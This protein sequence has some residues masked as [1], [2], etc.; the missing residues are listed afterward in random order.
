[1]LYFK[2]GGHMPNP[3]SLSWDA[4]KAKF[5][6]CEQ[7][8]FEWLCYLLF[9]REHNRPN[10]ILRYFN[11]AGIETEPIEHDGHSVGFQAK[12]LMDGI[13]GKKT[14]I[15][16][17]ISKA[18]KENPKLDRILYYLPCEFAKDPKNRKPPKYKTDIEQYARGIGIE[19]DWRVPSHFEAQLMQ[20][21]NR[22]LLEYFFSLD[23]GVI[24]AIKKLHDHS[25]Q[26][27]NPIKTSI[28]PSGKC[29]HFDRSSAIEQVMQALGQSV[30]II[31]HGVGGV[32]KTAIIKEMLGQ[33]HGFDAC[34]VV[35]TSELNTDH[36][37][38]LFRHYG[39]LT[40]TGFIDE[41]K[42]A[43]RKLFV[44]DSVESLSDFD[45]RGPFNTLVEELRKAGWDIVFTVR[46]LYFDEIK[47]M[48]DCPTVDV[49]IPKLTLD[50][51][52]QISRQHSIVLPTNERVQE[53]MCTP[54]YL[55]EYLSLQG[56]DLT[57]SLNEF[58]KAVWKQRIEDSAHQKGGIDQRRAK[59][60]I[61]L[62]QERC[63]EGTY[64]LDIP[65]DHDAYSALVHDE[66]LE[67]HSSTLCFITHDVYEEWALE[68]ILETAFVQQGSLR[69]MLGQIDSSLPMRRAFRDWLYE[70]IE[71]DGDN[72]QSNIQT[73]VRGKEIEPF[74][75]DEVLVALMKSSRIGYLEI[76]HDD[77]PT[78]NYS[79][80]DRM[81][82]LLLVGCSAPYFDTMSSASTD[83]DFVRHARYKLR[84]PYGKGWE[85]LITFATSLPRPDLL[86]K[87]AIP[88]FLAWTANNHAGAATRSAGLWALNLYRE[89]FRDNDY[90]TYIYKNKA[91]EIVP[92]ILNSAGEIKTELAEFLDT[93]LLKREIRF[94]DP[95]PKAILADLTASVEIL[96]ALPGFVIK[97]AWRFW[98]VQ[99]IE[100][101]EQ[102]E[103]RLLTAAFGISSDTQQYYHPSS[104][105]QTPILFLLRYHPR[106][107]L[108]FIIEFMN[109]AVANYA[110]SPRKDE[111]GE[112]YL[113]FNDGTTT[114]QFINA[115][116]WGIY[117]G[118]SS[119]SAILESIHMALERW[120]LLKDQGL[121]PE[122]QET[123]CMDLLKRSQSA[124]IT[125][126]VLSVVQAFPD[127]LFNV[128]AILL[129]V[130]RFYHLE[131]SRI[132]HELTANSLYSIGYGL[133][134]KKLYQDERIATCKDT[135][136]LR[137]LEDLILAYQWY[138]VDT[139]EEL[140]RRKQVAWG[141][142]DDLHRELPPENEQTNIDKAW[143][144]S[145]A[146]M[147]VRKMKLQYV[148]TEGDMNYFQP[149]PE[150]DGDL[151]QFQNRINPVSDE[152]LF[153]IPLQL[154]LRARFENN[155]IEYNKFPNY[156]VDP[157]SA[158]NEADE[159]TKEEE[160]GDD[161]RY[162]LLYR[163]API[164]VCTVLLRDFF[165]L[166]NAESMAFCADLILTSAIALNKEGYQ[167]SYRN[168]IAEITHGLAL[169]IRH[170]SANVV[171]AKKL[172]FTMVLGDNEVSD[173]ARQCV[174]ML[175]W[176]GNAADAQSLLAGYLRLVPGYRDYVQKSRSMEVHYKKGWIE[177]YLDSQ[178][179]VVNAVM[180]NTIAISDQEPSSLPG[181][182][183][184]TAVEMLPVS[185]LSHELKSVVRHAVQKV[186]SSLDDD[187]DSREFRMIESFWG[188]FSY[189]LFHLD[190]MEIKDLLDPF[191]RI[192]RASQEL[193]GLLSHI[194]LAEN[195]LNRP[196]TFWLI[197]NEFFELIT[198]VST[199]KDRVAGKMICKYLVF[200]VFDDKV[201]QWHSLRLQ[202][203]SF[204]D[205][206][207]HKMGANPATLDSIAKV[208]NS[209]ASPFWKQGIGWLAEL[210]SQ[211]IYQE[212]PV[213]T[214]YYIEEFMY[215]SI[216]RERRVIRQD[217]SLRECSILI[218]DFIINQ[219]SSQGYLLREEIL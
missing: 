165:P 25:Q 96:K 161:S 138:G 44:F 76:L 81:L 94:N 73:V 30:P 121:A 62:V 41:H 168:R 130:R 149:I 192:R 123:V 60:F 23:P 186:A 196:D 70:K 209:I 127:R 43:A 146:N 57:I 80:L 213:D 7:A 103:R 163:S 169:L 159:I 111:L 95:L 212:L 137:R 108:D 46:T 10:G 110:Q 66:I 187:R 92:I 190:E 90:V 100:E 79:L 105:F 205:K 136:R 82:L 3:I 49:E 61:E 125:A 87:W 199:L 39:S 85:E 6:G 106:Q 184:V 74:W 12:F 211:N 147:D 65:N 204:Y 170:S 155:P 180:D 141:I 101:D 27:L 51:L 50:E 175:L 24:E 174:C 164:A 104:A 142:L 67:K 84:I 35:K 152:I 8:N 102:F 14:E 200:D 15:T 124:S 4:F 218:L 171:Q 210:V 71:A 86:S 34:Y 178:S 118:L 214:I 26:V 32:G 33:E 219:G 189:I 91:R 68:H 89:F 166:L 148:K 119:A 56:T 126:V 151:R 172:L 18:K 5:N 28:D 131:K 122:D 20:D 64:Y 139:P 72:M 208:L 1:M 42:T 48:L 38:K 93:W 45:D 144:I 107:A 37:S 78:D 215:R 217:K 128:A 11:Q 40:I 55:S 117:R 29:I 157:L 198:N 116:L 59:C 158:L 132:D 109:K 176:E 181:E 143:R 54:K 99:E 13:S 113:Y 19:I 58:K 134:G 207:I 112:I 36:V 47:R 21:E 52:R 156:E 154:W 83:A 22:F 202:D 97:L 173:F 77:L 98:V 31:L 75:R 133:N 53:Y 182:Y 2:H 197:W 150:L 201:R 135:F 206:A 16:E 188:K 162:A 114:R 120:L 216:L 179:T 145:L 185:G 167:Y 88:V 9:C 193:D 115:H 17:D 140:E 63:K 129:R 160:K 195:E 69:G 191:T 153:H 203:L 194:I 183:L 177:E